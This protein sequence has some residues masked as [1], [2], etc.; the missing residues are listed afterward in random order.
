MID[1]W[2]LAGPGGPGNPFKTV[3]RFAPHLLKGFPGPPGLQ[4]PKIDHVRVREWVVF[5]G[6]RD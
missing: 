5:I 6:F 4:T 2:V 3:G 1:V